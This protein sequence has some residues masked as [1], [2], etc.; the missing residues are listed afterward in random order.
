METNELLSVADAALEL[1][2]HRTR[3]NQL[4]DNGLLP[5][6]RIGRA[7]V[8][9]R[10]DLALVRERPS[11]GRPPKPKPAATAG[12]GA[13]KGATTTGSA[14]GVAIAARKP[15]AVVVETKPRKKAAKKG[16]AK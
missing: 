6:Q 3:I 16:R 9:R 11:P 12:Q 8:I 2:V 7:Y 4:I 13:A 5:A 10:G 1:D 14:S 15:Q